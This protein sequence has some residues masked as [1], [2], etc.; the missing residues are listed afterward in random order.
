MLKMK[1]IFF[2]DIDIMIWVDWVSELYRTDQCP[3]ATIVALAQGNIA[4][5]P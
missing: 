5:C 2:D 4:S 1:N 3:R